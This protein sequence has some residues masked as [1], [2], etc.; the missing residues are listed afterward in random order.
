MLGTDEVSEQLAELFLAAGAELH[1][2]PIALP[3]D[4]IGQRSYLLETK[5]RDMEDDTSV[6]FKIYRAL[7]QGSIRHAVDEL[8]G[9]R[10]LH[11]RFFREF[12]HRAAT[13]VGHDFEHTPELDRHTL[14]AH[15]S[16]E[17]RRDPAI[18]FV[19]KVM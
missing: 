1:L 19:E 11:A 4:V 15:H 12:G 16:A 2:E 8:A 6:I 7:Q 14:G 13:L 9:G 17:V 18:G 5:V 3:L 10:H